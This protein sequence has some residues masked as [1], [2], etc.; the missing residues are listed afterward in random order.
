MKAKRTII[1]KVTE[2][3]EI[4]VSEVVEEFFE[5]YYWNLNDWDDT[6]DQFDYY[7]ED[8]G[9][10][11]VSKEEKNEILKKIKETF[12]EKVE[13]LKKKELS[14]LSSRERI[15]QWISDLIYD[16]RYLE[17][18]QVGYMLTSEEILDEILKNGNK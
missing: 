6:L 16:D 11:D 18:G 8:C 12:D 4:P 2:E 7:L 17:E 1:K 14:E 15:L 9:Y 10:E 3:V 5:R 13:K